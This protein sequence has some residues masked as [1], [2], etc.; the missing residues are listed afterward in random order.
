MWKWIHT[1][2]CPMIKEYGGKNKLRKYCVKCL[3]CILDESSSDWYKSS[4]VKRKI[5]SEKCRMRSLRQQC[6]KQIIEKNIDFVELPNEL[7]NQI[8][9]ELN[10]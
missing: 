6:I 9:V 5:K 1:P 10:H 3:I 8:K 2:S 7:K 4:Y